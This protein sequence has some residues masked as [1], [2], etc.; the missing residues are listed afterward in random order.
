[1]FSRGPLTPARFRL[2]LGPVAAHGPELPF[3]GASCRHARV[4][5]WLTRGAALATGQTRGPRT[6]SRRQWGKLTTPGRLLPWRPATS[7]SSA[8][9][10]RAAAATA[11]R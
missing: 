5:V 3:L 9:P 6:R 10:T 11:S 1:R 4:V 7:A 2:I 8:I